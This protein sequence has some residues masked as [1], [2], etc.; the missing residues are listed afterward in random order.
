MCS[1]PSEYDTIC[2]ACIHMIIVAHFGTG[3]QT[4][5]HGK[6]GTKERTVHYHSLVAYTKAH[7]L[8][9]CAAKVYLLCYLAA[10]VSY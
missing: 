8:Y 9:R 2:Y 1:A 7:L 10:S 4:G 3:P 6:A 5:F